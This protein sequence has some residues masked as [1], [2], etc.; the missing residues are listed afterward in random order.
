[1]E[2]LEQKDIEEIVENGLKVTSGKWDEK[3]QTEF[4][5]KKADFIKEIEEKGYTSK[6]EVEKQVKEVQDGLDELATKFNKQGMKEKKVNLADEIETRKADI[7]SVILGLNTKGIEIKADTLRA[8][9]TGNTDALKLPGIGQLGHKVRGLYNIFAKV[10]VASG[11]HNGVVRY[12]D[13][14][15]AT[16]IKAS[17]AIAE[18]AVFPESTAKFQ[19]YTLPLRKIGDTLPVSEEFGEDAPSA[20]AELGLFLDT[21]VQ[22]KIDD[23]IANGDN[24][25][26][27]LKGLFTSVPAYTATAQSI[28]SPNIYDLVKKVRTDIVKDR[29]SKYQPDFVAMNAETIDSLELEKDAN[30]QYIFR[31]ERSSIGTMT[32]VEDNNVAVNQLVVGDRRYGRIYEMGGVQLTKGQPN[33][34][35]N[36]DMAT[37]K[38]RKRLLFLVR[39]VDQTGFRKVTDIDAALSTLGSTPV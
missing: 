3:L 18:G 35:F 20:A 38:A 5:A 2:G 26:E 34:Q 36:E 11:D 28:P 13:W 6:E 16:T 30:G 17:A 19:E 33:A 23:Q 22:S 7:K 25:G 9:V 10:P 21:N 27:N 24:L 1:M 4:E 12:H 8:S 32:I 39:N 29:G 15:E 31:D 14:D 37:L